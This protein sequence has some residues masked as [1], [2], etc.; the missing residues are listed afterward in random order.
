MFC[1][2]CGTRNPDGSRFC[3]TCGTDLSGR[4]AGAPAP[5]AIA[6]APVPGAPAFARS[7]TAAHRHI[8]R[9]GVI[10]G[11]AAAVAIALVVA[12]GL[13]TGWF[14]LAQPHLTPGTYTFTSSLVDSSLASHTTTM[15]LSV[16]E[17][18]SV[19][20]TFERGQSFG[21][22]ARVSWAG[23]DHL[24]VQVPVTRTSLGLGENSKPEFTNV[25]DGLKSVTA[26]SLGDVQPLAGSIHFVFPRGVP[27]SI[28]G[29][30]ACWI[31]DENGSTLQVPRWLMDEKGSTLPYG[32]MN[33]FIWQRYEDDGSFRGG[34]VPS[35]DVA[36][37]VDSLKAGAFQGNSN[38]AVSGS[39]TRQNDRSFVLST[40]IGSSTNTFQY[41]R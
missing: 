19:V 21:G 22:N 15:V 36:A 8:G 20:F 26:L 34:Y 27:D 28:V 17:G 7:T 3:K 38:V 14:G 37:T 6:Q 13:R 16:A 10:A 39:W 18:D 12:V 1:P 33:L 41:H 32:D 25:T 31:T 24:Y 29:T 40:P 9:G 4:G 11:I 2:S 23:R 35:S 5:Q 30:W